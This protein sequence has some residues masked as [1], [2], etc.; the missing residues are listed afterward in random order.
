[1]KIVITDY[2]D[3][4]GRD[5]EYEKSILSKGLKDAEI[6]IYE[7]NGN[8]NEFLEVIE[9]ADAILTAFLDINKTVINACKNLKCI[10]I[11]AVGYD[12]VDLEE[13]T[14]RNIA[15]CPIGE[16]CTQEVADHTMSLI[17][18]LSRGIKHYIN[19]IDKKKIW[20]YHSISNL[21]RIEGQT[22][23]IF[24]FGKI[25]RAVAKRA[26]AFGMKV[27]AVDPYAKAEDA[28]M[29]GVTLVE[30]EYIW[31]NA[32]IISNHMNQNGS[33][34]NFFTI[35]EFRKME[36]KPIFINA[37]RGSSVNEDDLLQAIDEELLRGAGLDVLEEE[38]PDLEN[39]KLVGRENVIITPH[40]AFYSETSMRELQRI[41]CENIVYYL[42]GEKV[43]VNRI[44]NEII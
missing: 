27:V 18:T 2:K 36:K 30:P 41:S 25:G 21:Q 42:N 37:G 6:V 11:N 4:L 43:K 24:G 3:V 35:N 1:M 32:D 9:G 23:G 39:N 34:N 26:L 28:K 15:V 40:A 31:E 7:Y 8:Q 17:L 44:V 12:C 19:D 13:A 22:L 14:K 16:Y 38:N 20:K 33:N 10:S 5:L 29:L